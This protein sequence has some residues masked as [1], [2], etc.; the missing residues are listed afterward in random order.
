MIG[1]A[2]HHP[3]HGEME[4]IGCEIFHLPRIAVVIVKFRA[5]AVHTLHQH[6]APGCDFTVEKIIEEPGVQGYP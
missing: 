1:K 2:R 3:P 6:D 5:L 4:T